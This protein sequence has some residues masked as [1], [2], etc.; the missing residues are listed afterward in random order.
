MRSHEARLLLSLDWFKASLCQNGECVE[1]ASHNG[2]VVMRN[3]TQPG[4]VLRFTPDEFGAF[5]REVKASEHGSATR[6]ARRS[7]S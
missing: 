6:S 7:A 3:S 2:T 4:W 1:I 5:L